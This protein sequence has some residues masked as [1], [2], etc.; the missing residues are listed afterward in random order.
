MAKYIFPL[1]STFSPAFAEELLANMSIETRTYLEGIPSNRWRVEEHGMV[2]GYNVT[3]KVWSTVLKYV[4]GS[5]CNVRE[6]PGGQLA[7]QH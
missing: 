2:G 3:T 6:S 5:E 1:A 4:G 7:E